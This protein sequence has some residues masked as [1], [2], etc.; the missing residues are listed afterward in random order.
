M[1]QNK[2]LTV[3]I[4]VDDA[5]PVHMHVAIFSNSKRNGY[6]GTSRGKSGDLVIDTELFVEFVRRLDPLRISINT[7][8][9]DL[10]GWWTDHFSRILD[11]D[12]GGIY[13]ELRDKGED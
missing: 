5:N 11:E 8:L 6:V 12:E 2:E 1:E 3:V 10:P 13:Y 7:D 9:G 4:R